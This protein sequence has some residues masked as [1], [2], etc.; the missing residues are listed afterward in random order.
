MQK[1]KNFFWI[2]LNFLQKLKRVLIKVYSSGI[3]FFI[4]F[5]SLLLFLY[6]FE[7]DCFPKRETPFKTI[8]YIDNLKK[9]KEKLSFLENSLDRLFKVV[10]GEYINVSNQLKN[11]EDYFNKG[12]IKR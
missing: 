8:Y 7:R 11:D 9:E 1:K 10:N 2:Y 12:G 3:K 6:L 4:I 5:F